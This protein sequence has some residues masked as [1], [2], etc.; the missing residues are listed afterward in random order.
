MHREKGFVYLVGAGPGDP[1]YMTVKGMELLQTCDVV[2]YD[3]LASAELLLH[4]RKDCRKIYVGKKPGMHTMKQPEINEVIVREA[5]K[6]QF[7]VR[8]K[9][10]DPFVFG[11][12][13]EEIQAL[14][15]NGIGYEVVPGI[16]S[17]ISVP[18]SA[19]IPV[20]HRGV[21]QSFHVVTGHTADGKECLTDNYEAL[22]KTN[23]TLIFLMG[24]SHL[25]QIVNRLTME[26]M[27]SD[28]PVAVIQQG[29]TVF[30]KNVKG[31]LASIVDI[32]EKEGMQS[33]VIIVVGAVS[34]LEMKEPSYKVGMIGTLQF[35]EHMKAAII[36]NC[37]GTKQ[38]QLFSYPYVEIQPN[39]TEFVRNTLRQL[40]QYRWIV[41]TSA[42]GVRCFFEALTKSDIDR[43][44]LGNK[45]FAVI[46]KGTAKVLAEYGYMADF[47]PTSFY[48]EALGKELSEKMLAEADTGTVLLARA[49]IGSR[50]LTEQFENNNISYV[51]LPVYETVVRQE[52][53]EQTIEQLPYLDVVTFASASGVRFLCE[54]MTEEEKLKRFANVSV[55][56]IGKETAL[57]LEH[58]GIEHFEIAQS[59]TVEG[60]AAL[61][62]RKD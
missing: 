21:S 10:G 12:G 44:V 50:K 7:V 17:A 62:D 2:I 61:L 54:A 19:G 9:G 35:I 41:F 1:G 43:R 27:P 13:G 28:T 29:T 20:T 3:R 23:G 42:N 34:E 25:K 60:L 14:Q 8:L 56:C 40:N 18:M 46:G 22:A 15:E 11:R 55:L 30:Q 49:S 5:L 58:F 33:P 37:E 52:V 57:E 51:D 47:M 24:L 45:L 36:E 26:G 39:D 53:V 32:V 31:T 4:T 38:N 59:A 48:A 6:G 16:T